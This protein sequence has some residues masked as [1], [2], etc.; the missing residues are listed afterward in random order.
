MIDCVG[1]N[2]DNPEDVLCGRAVTYCEENVPGSSGPYSIIYRRVVDAGGPLSGWER[3]GPTCYT[4]EVPPRSGEAAPE[5]TEAMV[6]E[7]FHRTQFAAP[8]VSV[9]PVDNRALVN[10]PVYFELSW[11][12]EGHQPMEIDTTVLIGREVR[13]RPTLTSA[14]YHF[15][16][17]SSHGPTTSLG[18][19]YPTGDVTHEYAAEAMVTP[20]ITVIYGGDVSVD[21]G[22]WAAIPGSVTV[23]G[24]TQPL[25]ILT[26]TNRLYED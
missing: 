25:E 18:G 3:V 22:T 24:P 26:S 5:L 4:A 12:E 23:D 11:P 2:P 7:Q 19:P 15:G 6:I 14:T 17:G 21:G 1:N 9:Q 20:H 13:I 10:L 8:T 16:D